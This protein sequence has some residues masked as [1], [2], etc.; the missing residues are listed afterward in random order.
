MYPQELNESNFQQAVSEGLI[1]VD[2]GAPWCTPCLMME[3]VLEELAQRGDTPAI[4]KVNVDENSAL[5]A[6]FDVQGIPLLILLKDGDEVDRFV[7]FQSADEL[8][9]A[10]RKYTG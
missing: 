2:F 4:A 5:A 6:Q 9:D 8:S 1:L 3:P 7:G 10:L